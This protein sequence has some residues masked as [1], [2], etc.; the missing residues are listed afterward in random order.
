MKYYNFIKELREHSSPANYQ[1]MFERIKHKAGKRA[2]ERN[3]KLLGALAVVLVVVGIYFTLS[4]PGSDPS[5]MNYVFDE[6]KIN[7]S[8]II[9]YVFDGTF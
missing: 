3:L 7:D 1:A 4:R 9:S 8:P 6:E 2:A 5:I